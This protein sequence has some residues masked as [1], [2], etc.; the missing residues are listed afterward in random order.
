LF[1]Q[2]GGLRLPDVG[3]NEMPEKISL[4]VYPDR[5]EVRYVSGNGGIGWNRDW[6][7]VSAVC[8]GEYVGLEEIDNGLWNVYF[9][10]LKA[11]SPQ[12]AAHAHRG[13]IWETEMQHCVTHLP[14]R[15]CYLSPRPLTTPCSFVIRMERR[16]ESSLALRDMNP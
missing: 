14:R 15:F 6:V 7:N 2:P 5:L 11:G 12:G 8:I 1:K 13:S 4:F 3:L 16:G 10:P 9:G